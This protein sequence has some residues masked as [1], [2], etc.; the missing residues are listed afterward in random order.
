MFFKKRDSIFSDEPGQEEFISLKE[1]FIRDAR[2]FFF[3]YSIA[4][5][6]SFDEIETFIQRVE[7]MKDRSIE[8]IGILIGNKVDLEEHRQ[9]PKYKGEELATRYQ[10]PFF[11]TSAKTGENVE[12]MFQALGSLIIYGEPFYQSCKNIKSAKR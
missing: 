10:I 1:Q 11:E 4:A 3:V 5:L 8:G 12:E 2:C 7:R 9:V 6:Q